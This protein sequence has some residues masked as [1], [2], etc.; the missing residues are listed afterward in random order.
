MLFQYKLTNIVIFQKQR[1][2][3]KYKQ[4][5]VS[6][7]RTYFIIKELEQWTQSQH[8]HRSFHKLHHWKV[9]GLAE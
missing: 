1:T 9:A 4:N 5:I 3:T 7:Q 8:C 6:D 2:L